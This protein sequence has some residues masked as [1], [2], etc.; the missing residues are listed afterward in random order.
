MIGTEG[1]I[2]MNGRARS[3]SKNRRVRVSLA[4]VAGYSKN[5][6]HSIYFLEWLNEHVPNWQKMRNWRLLRTAFEAGWDACEM[7][8]AIKMERR[9]SP[10]EQ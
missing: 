8:N 5:E 10:E 7:G 6:T 3:S 2:G 9:H 4:P 1:M